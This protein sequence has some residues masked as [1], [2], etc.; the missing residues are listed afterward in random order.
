MRPAPSGL[1]QPP[2]G[3]ALQAPAAARV[4]AAPANKP[5]PIL[6]RCMMQ[7]QGGSCEEA[8]RSV[9]LV[10]PAIPRSNLLL[11]GKSDKI[12]LL[13]RRYAS[14]SRTSSD[15]QGS[16]CPDLPWWEGEG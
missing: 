3:A 4:T 15:S 7:L 2:G 8:E 9:A 1:P 5:R 11:A 10:P 13:P 16:F 12:V 14:T 6:L